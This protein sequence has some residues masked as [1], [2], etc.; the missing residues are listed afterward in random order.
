MII[1]K[2]PYR[3]SFFGG[4]SDY[5]EWYLQNG[6]LV[7]SSTI[8]KYIYI[9]CRELPPYF[10]HKHRIVYSIV[11]E[12]KKVSDI[13]HRVVKHAIKNILKKKNSKLGLEIH[14]DGD[15]PSRTGMGSSS[16]FVVGL[17]NVLNNFFN[18]EVSKN[19]LADQSIYLEQ[20]ILK[21]TVGSQDQIASSFGGF[22]EIIFKKNG[23]YK[24]NPLL[25]NKKDLET[26][27][28]NLILVF[29][30]VRP[31]SNTANDIAKTYVKQLQKNKKK[32]SMK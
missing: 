30:G 15:F 9:S 13:K 6:G 32:I 11:E 12:I 27:E 7:I 18:K 29:A 20:K 23:L 26:L 17:L 2:T 31:R 22:N 5:P 16:S 21:E 1:S 24:I 8:N 14:Y 3:I 4:G 10:N 19:Y 28:K 25:T